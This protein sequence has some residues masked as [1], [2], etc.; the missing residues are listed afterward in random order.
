MMRERLFNKSIKKTLIIFS[1]TFL[2]AGVSLAQ[3]QS[4]T[5]STKTTV[6]NGKT[7]LEHTV[8]SKD[9]YYQLSRIYGVPVKDI[10]NANN[11]KNLR[12]GDAVLI[13]A[14]EETKKEEPKKE[15]AKTNSSNEGDSRTLGNPNSETIQAKI[16]TEYKVGNNETL[17]SIA[18]RFSTTVDN[19]KKLNSLNTDTVREGQTLKIPDGNVVVVQKETA[20]AA[21][22]IPIPDN[23]SKEEIE[24]ETNRYGI[25]EKK[26]KG[27]GIWMENLESGG[28]SNLALHR[29]APVGTI[30]KITNPLTKSVTFAK[31]VGKFSDTSESRDAIVILS[32]S[33]ASYIGALDKRF[34]I[35]IAYG[36]PVN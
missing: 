35:E 18:K 29:T 31:V 9:T 1:A 7:F 24:F 34:L 3:A 21:I 13:P 2:F 14:K 30:L 16:L 28:R 32:K 11:K 25:R 10:M 17:Y 23:L 27:I 8:T 4:N 22:N 12:V 5:A 36:A 6:K 19:I 20:P 33:A 15:I 26:E